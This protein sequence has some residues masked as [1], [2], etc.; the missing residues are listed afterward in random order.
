MKL[1][2]GGNCSVPSDQ[3]NVRIIAGKEA[4]ISA[5]CLT[6]NGQVADASDV[7]FHGQPTCSQGALILLSEGISEG[8]D[9][10]FLVNLFALDDKIEKI[11]FVCAARQNQ[12]IDAL[13]SLSIQV[14]QQGTIIVS[15]DVDMAD[16]SEMALILGELYRRD[17]EWKFRFI[18]QGFKAGLKP[19][20]SLYGVELNQ[21]QALNFN[22]M[23][24]TKKTPTISLEKTS[25]YGLINLNLNWYQPASSD[26]SNRIDLDLGCFI[27]L[28][29]G[30]KTIVQA[31][32]KRFGHLN[33]EPFV[34][35]L[36]DDRTSSNLESKWLQINGKKWQEIDEILI[37]SFIYDGT[38]AWIKIDAL[39]SLYVPN[40]PP[41]EIRLTEGDSANGMCAIARLI[42]Q[43]GAFKV[44]RINQYFS[45]HAMLDKAFDWGFRWV[46]GSK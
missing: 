45:S 25:G 16:R 15:C 26:K 34:K 28:K 22:K 31:I 24:L 8:L 1:T 39:V 27:R 13:G 36:G 40:E 37:F 9:T 43:D 6:A 20:A 35:L 7:V 38:P 30:K 11:A 44:E 2:S 21:V 33:D 12:T 42:N 10:H 17:K 46:K 29:S 19:L 32:G 23:S 18:S 5:Y 3:L 4:D 41:L 14:E